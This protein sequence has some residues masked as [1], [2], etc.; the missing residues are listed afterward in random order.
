MRNENIDRR[1]CEIDDEGVEMS[2]EEAGRA[3]GRCGNLPSL[4]H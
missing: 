4:P 3:S 1:Y 2:S